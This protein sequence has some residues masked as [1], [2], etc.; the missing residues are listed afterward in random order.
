[1]ISDSHVMRAALNP[2]NLDEK[3]VNAV[4]ARIEL[5]LRI[6]ASLTR[7]Q[8]LSFQTLDPRLEGIISYGM[9]LY[10]TMHA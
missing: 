3:Q 2:V 8:T 6:G 5:D 4:A 9:I 7:F 10:V 1:M